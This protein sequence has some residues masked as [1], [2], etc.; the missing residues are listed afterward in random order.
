[1]KQLGPLQSSPNSRISLDRR[2]SRR[3]F[4][5]WGLWPEALQLGPADTLKIDDTLTHR[6]WMNIDSSVKK[7]EAW[8][9]EYGRKGRRG[10]GCVMDSLVEETPC[11]LQY[12]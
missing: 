3:A 9:G 7:D 10:S 12:Q 6:R 5:L 8:G 1:M 11:G 2:V 4:R